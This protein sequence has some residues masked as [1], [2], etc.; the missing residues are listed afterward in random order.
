MKSEKK[1]PASA[2]LLI[3]LFAAIYAPALGHGFVKDDFRW[4]A[5]AEMHSRADLAHI[6]STNV[7]FYRPL[8]TTS[9]AF[10]RAIWNLD[11]RGYALTNVTLVLANAGLL[12]LL[13]RA[14]SLPREGALFAAAVWVF[15]FHGI[16]MALLWTSGRTALLLCLFAQ[17]AAF[18][19]LSGRRWA[20]VMTGVLALAAML[21]KEEA[22]LLPPLFVVL[23]LLHLRQADARTIFRN[24]WPLCAAL[25]IYLLARGESGAFTIANAPA[26]YRP[27]F[28]LAAVLKNIGEYLDRGATFA[29]VASVAAWLAAPRGVTITDDERRAIRF[30]IAW[31]LA[32]Y[33]ITIFVPVRSSLYAVAPSIGSA[34]VAG[35][36]ASRAWRAAPAR[37]ARVA[38]AM[39][40]LIALLVPVYRSRNHGLVEPADLAT[41]SLATIQSAARSHPGARDIVLLDNPRAPVTLDSAFGALFPDAIHLFVGPEA[42][43]SITNEAV[44]IAGDA[45]V[46]ELR[47]GRLVQH[48]A[49]I[50]G[51]PAESS[52]SHSG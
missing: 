40:V 2:A 24:S 47:D 11:A 6:F 1:I 42:R 32:M 37:F 20:P 19:L 26:Y 46:F 51:R 38:I 8:V 3:A 35:A 28:D 29:A 39:I 49:R 31:F 18:A 21:S 48:R 36:F 12:F 22:V 4:I 33:A 7:G 44:T 16:N 14:V 25:V 45:L 9:F 17:A 27:T 15:N 23:Q 34:L 43:G 50:S 30:G 52:A 41:Q 13:A 5:S 10:D